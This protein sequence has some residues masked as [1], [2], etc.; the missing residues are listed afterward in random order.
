MNFVNPKGFLDFPKERGNPCGVEARSCR[1]VRV[2]FDDCVLD[3]KSRRFWRGGEEVSLEPQVF[4]IIFLLA[5]NAGQI[6][7]RD[8]L[9]AT[10]WN[11][12]IVSE[13]TIDTRI[14]STR[15]AVGDTGREQ[16]VIRTIPRRGFEMLAEVTRDAIEPKAG[17]AT[18]GHTVRYAQ[19][20][21]GTRIAYA[22]SGVGSPLMRAGHILTHL[23]KDLH[24]PVFRPYIEALSEQH[25]LIRYDTRGTGL[26]ETDVDDFSLDAYV[27]DMLAVA[28][29]AGLRQFPIFAASLGVAISI[30]FAANYPERVSRLVLYGGFA[31]GR[32]VRNDS[33]ARDEAMALNTLVREGWGKPES[34]YMS[35]FVSMFCPDATR[36]ERASLS[37]TQNA[38]ATPENATRIRNA[39]DHYDVSECLA[40]I[41]APTLIIHASGDALVPVSQGR[42]LAAEIPGAE[43]K[44][45]ESNNHIPLKSTP[46]FEEIMSAMHDFLGRET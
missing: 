41:E 13:A 37:E 32:M 4:D 33:D 27:E 21:D 15:N 30:R 39:S 23:E 1:K 25:Q 8:E 22:V 16:R 19:S 36:I 17:Q 38:S 18:V 44:L 3:P 20:S 24:S 42:R 40:N 7:T 12:R 11:G 28:D 46:A 29:H 5:E 34:A 45:I 35:A 43:F 31:L 2:C 6:V 9:V 10:V 26:S 14:S